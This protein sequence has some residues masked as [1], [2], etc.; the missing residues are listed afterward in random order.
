MARVTKPGGCVAIATEY[1]LLPE[2]SHP[3]YFTKEEIHRRLVCA[4][5]DLELISEIDWKLPFPEYLIDSSTVP[6]GVDRRRRHVVLN[7]GH[8]QWT[9]IMLIFRKR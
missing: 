6:N 9:S 1:L 3:E 2:Y 4:S 7:D 8:V 5:D